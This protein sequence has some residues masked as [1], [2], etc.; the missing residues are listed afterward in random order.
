MVRLLLNY[1]LAY[2]VAQATRHSLKSCSNNVK[3]G[4]G[5]KIQNNVSYSGGNRNVRSYRYVY[6]P[7]GNLLRQD[8]LGNSYYMTHAPVSTQAPAISAPTAPSAP[9]APIAT[10]SP[11]TP[12]PVA[13]EAPPASANGGIESN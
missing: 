9:P 1:N 3:I 2:A 13:P 4:N 6:D 7:D 10:P 8:D 11:A 5:C 12:A